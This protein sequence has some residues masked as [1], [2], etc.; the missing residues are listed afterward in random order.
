[1]TQHVLT[2][3]GWLTEGMHGLFFWFKSIGV[4]YQAYQL[5]KQT[6][7]ELYK[8]SDRE[9]NDMGLHRGAIAG[10]AQQ[11]YE[12]VVNEILKGWV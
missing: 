2:A 5:K 9:L 8:C 12:Q 3:A 1:M 4:R 11:H 6:M 10:L 7:N